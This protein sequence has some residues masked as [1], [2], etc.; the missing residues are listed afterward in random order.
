MT[1]F[2]LGTQ[3]I[4]DFAAFIT[5]YGT[6]YT[7]TRVTE[8]TDSMG[9]VSAVSET[10]FTVYGMIQDINH[11]ERQ[12]ADMG[13]AVPGNRK[14]YCKALATDGTSQ[15]K[16]GDIVTDQYSV[17]WKVVAILKQP[18]V[19]SSEVFRNCVIKS[20]TSEGS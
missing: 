20:I 18:Y 11:K 10:T 1:A 3:A 6:T 8:T 17:Q 4:S 13:L 16:E 5:A 9:T 15:V 14:F 7:I 12:V 2:N 19:V